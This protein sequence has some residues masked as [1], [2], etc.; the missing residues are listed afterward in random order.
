MHLPS[1][2][3]YFN[4]Y[5][6]KDSE[7]DLKRGQFGD[8]CIVQFKHSE[9]IENILK[10][11]YHRIQK[12][13][14]SVEQYNSQKA[15]QPNAGGEPISR[16]NQSQWHKILNHLDVIDLS[17]VANTC[18]RLKK[19]GEQ[20][21]SSKF[22]A[23][24]WRAGNQ[25]AEKT[26]TTFGHLISKL[27]VDIVEPYGVHF[28]RIVGKCNRKLLR[29]L[30]IYMHGE[31]ER[32]PLN[33]NT[34][35]GLKVLFSQ[36]HQLEINCRSFFNYYTAM[37]LFTSCSSLKSITINCISLSDPV[38]NNINVTFSQLNEIKLQLNATI[39]DNGLET[40]LTCNPGIKKL[41]IDQCPRL[42]SKSIEI[43]ARCVPWLEELTLGP[44]QNFRQPELRPFDTLFCLKRLRILLNPAWPL[45]SVIYNAGIPIEYLDLFYVDMN[46]ALINQLTSMKSIKELTIFSHSLTDNHLKMIVNKL[47]MLNELR[48]GYTQHVTIDGL[49]NMLSLETQNLTILHLINVKRINETDKRHLQTFIEQSLRG[50][51]SV[52]LNIC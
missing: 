30:S 39:N 35:F 51:P 19:F 3:E 32:T 34:Q 49:A 40:L 25:N 2:V 45:M 14:L 27:D 44:L 1:I 5:G 46:E 13:I 9:G 37:Q 41:Y 24:T 28:D 23:I 36:L 48:L 29:N 10:K 26:F 4:Q 47:P 38:S 43:I 15:N 12:Y 50:K 20:V 18:V 21:F 7:W 33:G 22:N 42:T 6:G 11:R 16:L 8:Y 52:E 17:A 31:N